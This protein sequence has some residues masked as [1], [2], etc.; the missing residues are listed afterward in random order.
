MWP[1][2]CVA[3]CPLCN[4]PYSF[5][6]SS[7]AASIPSTCCL[8]LER[9]GRPKVWYHTALSEQAKGMV[10]AHCPDTWFASGVG[11]HTPSV[12][13]QHCNPQPPPPPLHAKELHRSGPRDWH[14]AWHLVASDCVVHVHPVVLASAL[15]PFWLSTPA[16]TCSVPGTA[17]DVL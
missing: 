13:M 12:R 7:P 9:Q 11:C 5:I 15:Q 10:P 8:L 16:V 6:R 17:L 2:V 3:L 4:E 14:W 1:P